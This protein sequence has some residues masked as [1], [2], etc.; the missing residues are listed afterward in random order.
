MSDTTINGIDVAQLTAAA[1][2]VKT[3]PRAGNYSFF[4]ETV[5][6]NGA[7]S[8]SKIQRYLLNDNAPA[9]KQDCFAITIDE[10]EELLG[11]NTAA[12]PVE[13][14]LAGLAGCLA[15]GI[16]YNAA[17][18]GIHLEELRITIEGKLDSRGFLGDPNVRPGYKQIY[19]DYHIKSDASDE[20]NQALIKYVESTSPVMDIVSRPVPVETRIR[21]EIQ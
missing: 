19:L 21:H 7:V 20:Q 11:T 9:T 17:A 12:N 8:T 1:N 6:K 15:V 18:Q 13:T 5:W 2:A 14:V 4:S 10:P 16:S 3:D